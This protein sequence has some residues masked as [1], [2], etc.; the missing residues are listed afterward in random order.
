MKCWVRSQYQSEREDGILV[1]IFCCCAPSCCQHGPRDTSLH[2]QTEQVHRSACTYTWTHIHISSGRG[3]FLSRSSLSSENKPPELSH[4]GVQERKC[5]VSVKWNRESIFFHVLFF[6]FFPLRW[7]CSLQAFSLLAPCPFFFVNSILWWHSDCCNSV[8]LH[9]IWICLP[10]SGLP[11][12][13]LPLR[14]AG[15]ELRIRIGI[16]WVLL[17][18]TS[19]VWPRESNLASCHILNGRGADPLSRMA[20]RVNT[21]MMAL[22]F[23]RSQFIMLLSLTAETNVMIKDQWPLWN[24]LK[25][26]EEH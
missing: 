16:P 21:L 4:K 18:V 7:R 12:P 10:F 13:P 24:K 1:L 11:P 8:L 23:S 22:H 6:F 17:V 3:H 2:F 9:G 15:T 14:G 20:E 25:P 19:P 26:S 5:A